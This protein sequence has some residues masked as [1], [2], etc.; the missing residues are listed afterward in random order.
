MTHVFLSTQRHFVFSSVYL[1]PFLFR[2]ILFWPKSKSLHYFS[3]NLIS[4][5]LSSDQLAFCFSFL[6]FSNLTVFFFLYYFRLSVKWTSRRRCSMQMTPSPSST[7]VPSTW[8]TR[9]ACTCA[10]PKKGSSSFKSVPSCADWDYCLTN[11]ELKFSETIR[12]YPCTFWRH[13]T[14]GCAIFLLYAK[15]R[16]TVCFIFSQNGSLPHYQTI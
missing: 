4:I 1:C 9:S 14:S 16:K 7:N 15:N 2:F 13:W 5:F 3:L 8:R 11:Q 10:F 6:C 12:N